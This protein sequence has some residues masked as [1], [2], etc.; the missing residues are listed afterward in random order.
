MTISAYRFFAALLACVLLH[1]AAAQVAAQPI[2]LVGRW[3][4]SAGTSYS[5]NSYFW[6]EFSNR[7]FYSYETPNGPRQTGAFQVQGN[8]ITLATPTGGARTFVVSFECVGNEVYLEFRD[9]NTGLGEGYW[10]S[11]PR[12][13]R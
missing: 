13:C 7:G 8:L 11:P 4:K 1:S 9:A 5:G 3:W 2:S 12:Y 10:A 6:L